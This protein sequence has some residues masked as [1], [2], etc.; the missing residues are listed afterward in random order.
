MIYAHAFIQCK[1]IMAFLRFLENDNKLTLQN[2]ID[3]TRY[4]QSTSDALPYTLV[5]LAV[6]QMWWSNMLG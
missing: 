2:T 5:Q 4:K 6:S 3:K 1:E